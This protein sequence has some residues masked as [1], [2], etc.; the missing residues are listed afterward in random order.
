[1]TNSR[2]PD[3]V[4]IAIHFTSTLFRIFC[5]S[6]WGGGVGPAIPKAVDRRL[7]GADLAVQQHLAMGREPGHIEQAHREEDEKDRN[8]QDAPREADTVDRRRQ[9]R[10]RLPASQARLGT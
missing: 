1:M 7:H 2:R 8:R 10:T 4:S 3:G 9:S 6:S 5:D